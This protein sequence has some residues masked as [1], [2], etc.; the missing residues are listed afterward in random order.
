MKLKTGSWSFGG[1]TPD[2]FENHISKSVPLYLEGLKKTD[3]FHYLFY[4][5]L[6]PYKFLNPNFI[7]I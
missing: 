4:P 3:S 6:F 2:K 7:F 1:K 5:L